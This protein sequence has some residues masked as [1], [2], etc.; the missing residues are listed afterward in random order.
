MS[1]PARSAVRLAG[2]TA[3]HAADVPAIYQAGIDEGNATF[4]PPRPYSTAGSLR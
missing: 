3:H 1:G 2:M 4:G